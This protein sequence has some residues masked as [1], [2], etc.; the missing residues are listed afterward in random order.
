MTAL[1][2]VALVLGILVFVVLLLAAVMIPVSRLAKRRRAELE[3]EL[4]G[5]GRRVENA[6]GLGQE[7]R[8]RSQV[9]GN[10]WLAL[11][12]DELRFRQWIPARE[13]RIPL[14]A[15][16]AVET[17]R[18]WLG[19]SVGSRLLVVRWRDEAGAEDAMAWSVRDLD[20]WLA[21]LGGEPSS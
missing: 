3:A 16:T 1:E 11:T 7:S 5:A 9:R 18:S 2:T 8:G 4:G 21:A 13:T 19:K 17:K 12:D 14:S 20:E 6:Q 10:G 15:V